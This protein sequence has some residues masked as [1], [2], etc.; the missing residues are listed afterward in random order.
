MNLSL[1]VKTALIVISILLSQNA[2]SNYSAPDLIKGERDGYAHF[3]GVLVNETCAFN[4]MP[5][6][7]FSLKESYR[8]I[9]QHNIEVFYHAD[10]YFELYSCVIDVL[11]NVNIEVVDTEKEVIRLFSIEKETSFS[12]L[13]EIYKNI[14][15]RYLDGWGNVK[16]SYINLMF[17]Y[18]IEF[19]GKSHV[20]SF[21]R[22]NK[23]AV[24]RLSYP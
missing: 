3:N 20:N 18:Q 11:N 15:S 19:H 24:V 5:E 8:N 4:I 21:G 12:K 13:T 10:V 6:Q 1:V 14:P 7:Y 23:T 17:N 16:D 2:Y 9:D 22:L